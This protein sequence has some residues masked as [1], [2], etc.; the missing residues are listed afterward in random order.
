M[1]IRADRGFTLVEVLVVLA[2]TSLIAV[3]LLQMMTIL[4]RGYDQAGR[5]Q[6]QL[7][8]DTMRFNWFRE[9]IGVMAASLDEEFAFRGS[10]YEITGFTMAPL[11][12]ESGTLTRVS[13]TLRD[14]RDGK[15]LWYQE[16]QHEPL[17]IGQWPD[18]EVSFAYRGQRSDW[19]DSWPTGNLPA[20]V[21]PYRIKMSLQDADSRKEIFA[22]VNVRR[23]GRY[24]FRDLVQ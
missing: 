10:K 3:L 21:L 23:T 11:L 13:W 24:D 1:S 15:A 19:L 20:G 22:A 9:T 6:G 16:W 5:I 8:M 2:F 18:T 7:A 4:L 14:N 12:A 17:L